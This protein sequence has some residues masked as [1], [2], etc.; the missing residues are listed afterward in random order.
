MF[1]DYLKIALRNLKIH[2]GYSSINIAGLANSA[3]SLRHE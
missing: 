3:D 1:K 2:K